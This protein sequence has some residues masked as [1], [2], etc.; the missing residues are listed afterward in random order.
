VACFSIR[1][2]A[3]LSAD[4]RTL[5]F[6]TGPERLAQRLRVGLHTIQGS[7]KYDLTQ[8]LPWF[9]LLDKPNRALLERSIRDFF[10][11]FPEVASILSL[12]FTR[13]PATRDLSVAYQLRMADGQVVTATSA[14][15]PLA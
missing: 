4:G 9:Q 1:G 11:S 8:G 12:E 3:A 2:D 14:I 15:T 7:Y 5:L 6:A 10:L 13:D